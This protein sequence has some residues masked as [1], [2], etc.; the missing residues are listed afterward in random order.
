M[1][2]NQHI[3]QLSFDQDLNEY[4]AQHWGKETKFRLI[5]KSLDA[6][7]A[8]R[9]KT[10]QF[11]YTIEILQNNKKNIIENIAE[12]IKPT[13]GTSIATP[14][15]RPLIVG[16]GP[17]GLFCAKKLLD[18]GIRSI[19]FER[20]RPCLERMKDIAQYW[21]YGKL[22]EESNVC[23]GEGGA[24]LFSDGKLITRVKSPFTPYVLKTLVEFGAPPEC[25]YTHDPHIGSNRIRHIIHSLTKYLQEHG[26]EIHYNSK[27]TDFLFQSQTQTQAQTLPHSQPSQIITGLKLENGKEF[28]SPY[29]VLAAGHS[30]KD[31]YHLLQRHHVR[32]RPKDFAV[33]VR[34]EH[35]R[36]FIDQSQ[37]GSFCEHPILGSAFY[38]LHHYDSIRK[39]GVHVGFYDSRRT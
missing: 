21:R 29:V 9:G 30:A 12:D 35:P 22:N 11:H 15:V 7:H 2:N 25:E 17:S 14:K 8:A 27:V 39:R 38:K 28:H 24:G 23:F 31:I 10:P 1:K 13:S 26:V 19:V 16:M 32:M 20:G 5:K 3:F 33:G 6:R 4:V 34:I 36:P 18:L 37:Y